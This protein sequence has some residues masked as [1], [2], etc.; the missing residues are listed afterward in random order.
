MKYLKFATG[1]LLLCCAQLSFAMTPEQRVRA[2]F[3]AYSSQDFTA[4]ASHLLPDDLAY[5]RELMA[6]TEHLSPEI[7]SEFYQTLYGPG[8]TAENISKLSNSEY[9]ASFMNAVFSLDPSLQEALDISAPQL[10]GEIQETSDLTHVLVRHQ[11]E[12]DGI[13]YEEMEV[14]SLRRV[15]DDWLILLNGEFENIPASIKESFLG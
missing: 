6:F 1:I 2:Y 10:I 9:F 12:F 15:G 14:V 4:L 7:R 13:K 8:I 5:F 3:Q 11:I